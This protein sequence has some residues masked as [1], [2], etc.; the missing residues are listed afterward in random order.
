MHFAFLHG[1]MTHPA[2]GPSTSVGCTH[3]HN[4]VI[5]TLECNLNT[6]LQIPNNTK[7][8]IQLHNTPTKL[9]SQTCVSLVPALPQQLVMFSLL[10]E[11]HAH[12]RFISPRLSSL[13]IARPVN[14][15]HRPPQGHDCLPRIKVKLA[16]GNNSCFNSCNSISSMQCI[17]I[18]YQQIHAVPA[19]LRKLPTP[20]YKSLRICVSFYV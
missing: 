1:N 4:G 7:I 9:F 12:G 5:H 8:H 16:I 19:K 14:R 17:H 10:I 20:N 6:R 11:N 2:I 13:A 3:K 15:E 18:S